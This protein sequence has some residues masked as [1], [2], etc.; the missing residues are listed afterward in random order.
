MTSSNGPNICVDLSTDFDVDILVLS[1][2]ASYMSVSLHIKV[3]P[4]S[5]SCL[6]ICC[7]LLDIRLFKQTNLYDIVSLASSSF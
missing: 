4:I 5:K 7:I 1:S 3:A 2:M 6:P